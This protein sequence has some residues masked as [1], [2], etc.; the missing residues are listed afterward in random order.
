MRPSTYTSL[1]FNKRSVYYTVSFPVTCIHCIVYD[2][3][4]IIFITCIVFF[5]HTKMFQIIVQ[6]SFNCTKPILGFAKRIQSS[7]NLISE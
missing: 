6:G 5:F 3:M 1:I 7:L 4:I 2:T